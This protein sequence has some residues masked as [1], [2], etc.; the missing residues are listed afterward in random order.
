MKGKCTNNIGSQYCLYRGT[1]SLQQGNTQGGLFQH[2][3]VISSVADAYGRLWIKRL[4]II[5]FPLGLIFLWCLTVVQGT[6]CAPFGLVR[7]LCILHGFVY[8]NPAGSITP[9]EHPGLC[10]SPAR[11]N[12]PISAV[13]V[14]SPFRVIVSS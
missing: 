12:A 11:I 1:F 9:C 5:E 8:C 3:L 6:H 4:N 2:E 7:G 13:S 10:G 14:I